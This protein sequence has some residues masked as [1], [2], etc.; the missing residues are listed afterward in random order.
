[1]KFLPLLCRMKR[2]LFGLALLATFSCNNN[3]NGTAP[4]SENDLDAGR[5]FIRA[6]LDG[7]WSDAKQYMLTDS[8]NV[9]LLETAASRYEMKGLQEKRGYRESSITIYDTRKVN[10][11]ASVI[12]YSNTFKNVRDSL[13]I[14]RLN[15]QWLVDLKYSLLPTDTMDHVQ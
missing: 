1:M 11:S 14:V 10:D 8:V 15:G 13:K 4:E 9:Q 7:K 3:N 5:N 6:A 12:K 2:Y